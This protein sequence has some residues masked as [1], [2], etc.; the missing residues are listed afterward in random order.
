MKNIRTIEMSVNEWVDVRDNPIQRNTVVH[1]VRAINGHLKEYSPTHARV[2]AAKL[3]RELYKLDGHTRSLLWANGDLTPPEPILV[4]I[5]DANC[6]DEVKNLY[7]QFD[8]AK[9]TENATDKVY[10]ALR[11]NNI[12][13]ASM[14]LKT[15]GLQTAIYILARKA[16]RGFDIY[17]EIKPWIEEVAIVDSW[18][19]TKHKFTAGILAVM[20][21]T[22]KIYGNQKAFDY[23]VKY[24]N[25]DGIKR[26][27]NRDGVQALE[28]LINLRRAAKTLS[29]K[30]HNKDIA[31]KTISCFEHYQEKKTY[32]SG[33]RA[34]NLAM[35]MKKHRISLSA[36]A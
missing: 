30:E 35:Y 12:T 10:G 33:V 5:Y 21:L 9:A 4:D 6:I 1:A 8:N 34:T 17:K 7:K 19:F 11:E 20:L 2:S 3:N 26:G 36:E 32:S 22:V 29:G 27:N 13:A 28:E 24:Y 16:S 14:L 15:G 18:G 25:G 23:W 31:E